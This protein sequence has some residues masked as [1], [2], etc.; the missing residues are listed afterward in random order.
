MLNKKITSETS[1]QPAQEETKEIKQKH[2]LSKFEYDLYKEEDDVTFPIIRVKRTSTSN[3]VEKWKIISD[4]KVICVIEGK[5]LA[6][7]ECEFLRTIDGTNWL[8]SQAKLGIKSFNSLKIA[9][10][11]KLKKA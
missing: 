10:K 9:I 7:K 3:K 2:P 5:K 4:N 11:K 6:K 1:S 8:L